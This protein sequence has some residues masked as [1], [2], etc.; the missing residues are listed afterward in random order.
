[1]VTDGFVSGTSV[2]NVISILSHFGSVLFH[3]SLTALALLRL[4]VL[5]S[6]RVTNPKLVDHEQE[7]KSRGKMYISHPRIPR[8]TGE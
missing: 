4:K 2:F 1:M 6:M 5:Y 3:I 8:N 7:G